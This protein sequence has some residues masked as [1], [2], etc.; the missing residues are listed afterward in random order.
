MEAVHIKV[1]YRIKDTKEFEEIPKK[2]KKPTERQISPHS[3]FLLYVIVSQFSM[4]VIEKKT[5]EYLYIHILTMGLELQN[6]LYKYTLQ[7]LQ[8]LEMN[9]SANFMI[10]SFKI[11]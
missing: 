2:S 9:T 5:L 7:L 4:V 6:I 3:T 11:P 10:L 1:K 8:T